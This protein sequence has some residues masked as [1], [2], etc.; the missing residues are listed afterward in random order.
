MLTL[1]GEVCVK[2]YGPI[3]LVGFLDAGNVFAE[4]VP[5]RDDELLWGA[6]GGLRVFSPVGAIGLEL[7]FPLNRR[8]VDD[9]FQ[10]YITIGFQF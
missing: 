3:G 5:S 7:G 10:F 9:S 6:G 8:S 2:V 1:S 4:S